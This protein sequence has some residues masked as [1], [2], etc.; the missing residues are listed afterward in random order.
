MQS[1]GLRQQRTVYFDYLRVLA[2][3]AVIILHVSAQNWYKTDVNSFEWQVFNFFD[4]IVRWAV[5]IFVMISGA[6]FLN[7]DITIR[8]I[9]TKYIRRM[10]LSF[11]VWSTLYAV[12]A[13][14]DI[15]SKLY[16]LVKGHYHM[17]FIFMIT[18]MYILTP[19]IKLII[20]NDKSIKYYLMLAL[21]FAFIIPWIITLVNDFGNEL[22]VKGVSVISSNIGSMQMHLVL[23]YVSY[24]ILG[25]YINKS[26]LDVRRRVIIYVLGLIGFVLTIVLDLIVALKTQTYCDHYYGAFA[27]NV[28]FEALA[29]FTWFKYR[30]YNSDTLNKLMKKLSQYSFGAYLVHALV[31]EQLNVCIGLNTLSFNSVLAVICIGIIVFLISF[32]ISALLNKIPI[33]G[34]YIV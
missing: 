33:V 21:M 26:D 1:E 22:I 14:G 25:Y 9:F 4:S 17:W 2:T 18:G 19:I 29:V 7:R 15:L 6:L 20:V 13:D 5:P 32:S 10:G 34:K 3:F 30:D 16:E 11:I 28:L 27:V 8:K 12:F 23:G 24:F 31:I